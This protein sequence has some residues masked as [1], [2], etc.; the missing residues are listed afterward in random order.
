RL[1]RLRPDTRVDWE[2]SPVDRLSRLAPFVSWGEPVPRII[3]GDLVWLVDGYLATRSFPLSPRIEWRGRRIG[4]LRSG[5]VGTVSA[6]A[7]ATRIFLRPGADPLAGAWAAV[8][9]GR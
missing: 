2:L 3:D 5:F 6:E 4:S 9:G 8:S 1:A 7:G